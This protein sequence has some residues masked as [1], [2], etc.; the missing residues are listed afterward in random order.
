MERALDG[1]DASPDVRDSPV[2]RVLQRFGPEGGPTDELIAVVY[3]ELRAL[4][5]AWLAREAPGHTL[6]PTALV[7]EAYLRLV[8]D[9]EMQWHSRRVRRHR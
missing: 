6:Q 7:H 4:A 1:P 2:T 8:T 9:P 5:R 3:A